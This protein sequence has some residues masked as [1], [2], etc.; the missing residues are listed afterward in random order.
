M[1]KATEVKVG[2]TDTCSCGAIVTCGMTQGSPDYPAKQ[3]WQVDGKA[4]FNYDFKTKTTTCKGVII[5]DPKNKATQ[6]HA[7]NPPT[8]ITSPEVLRIES[9]ID[10]N[11]VYGEAIPKAKEITEQLTMGYDTPEGDKLII[12]Q[13]ILR[14]YIHFYC[15]RN[16]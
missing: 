12:T 15:A 1:K 13:R 7:G 10:F 2:E 16:L 14:D 4:H 6:N 3:Q 5:E 11:K 9:F 8:V